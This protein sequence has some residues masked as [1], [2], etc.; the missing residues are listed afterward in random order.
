M[1]Q[2][3]ETLKNWFRTGLKPT[4]QQFW[5][6]LDSYWHKNDPIPGGSVVGFEALEV[7]VSN[8]EG[9]Q[10][11]VQL[12]GNTASITYQIPANRLLEKFLIKSTANMEFRV[13]S[14]PGLNDI[15]VGSEITAGQIAI[16]YTDIYAD[17]ATKNIYFENLA[18][19]VTI[20][21]YLR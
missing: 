19:T 21:V 16:G 15:P 13:S 9:F 6:L 8:L 14:S 2:P 20:V 12:S 10:S 18:G 7:R 3:I 11:V 1:I 17:G 5:D 4:Q